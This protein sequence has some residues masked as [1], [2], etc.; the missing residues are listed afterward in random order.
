MFKI[1]RRL[2]IVLSLISIA[3]LLI[4]IICALWLPLVTAD[5]V[6]IGINTSNVDYI[7]SKGYLMISLSVAAMIGGI[8]NTYLVSKISYKLCGELRADVYRKVLRFSKH[9]FDKFGTSSLIT[10]NTNDVTQVQTLVENGLKLLIQA[11]ALLI[12]GIIMTGLLSPIL[13]FIFLCIV[14]FIGVAYYAIYRFANPLYGKMQRMLDNLNKFFR[15]GLTGVKVIRAFGKECQEYEKYKA[16]N[17]EYTKSYIKAGT[18]MSLSVPF[19]TML[20]SIVTVIIVWVGG[21]GIS[22]G[23]IEIGAIM[24]AISYSLQILMG[25]EMLTTVILSIPRGQISAKRIYEVLDIPISINDPNVA[26]KTENGAL[27]FENVDFRY[28]SAER[29]TLGNIRFT[30][31]KGQTLAII[32]STGAGKSSLVNLIPRLYDVEK[33]YIKIGGTDIRKLE[34]KTL[35]DLVSFSP[36]KSTLFLGTVRSNM[37][38]GKPDAMDEEIWAALEMA[39]ATEFV[40]TLPNGLDS[41]VEKNGGNFS[42]GQKQRLCIARALIKDAAIYIFDDSFS[43]LDFKTD[44]EVR[45]AMGSKLK[46][47]ITIIVAQ[48]IST[49]MEADMIAVLDNGKLAGLGTHEQL[50]VRCPVYKEIINSQFYKEEAAV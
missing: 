28:Q 48:R 6:N 9:E 50:K 31:N 38:V 42:G 25:F 30:V 20:I 27:T 12:G 22:S 33:G 43:A 13:A 49:V 46:N 8:C 3:F 34:Q 36:Q 18:I 2:P 41:T 11:P 45:R 4:Q 37:L 32:G 1:I 44:A 5:I 39:Q 19:V 26:K 10:R 24:G 7:W 29:K 35:H 17:H 15:E 21:K 23:T 47:A 40:L 16:V 14:P